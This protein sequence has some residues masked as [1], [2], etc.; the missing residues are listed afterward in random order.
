MSADS[1]GQTLVGTAS[2]T[3]RS[4]IQ[5][6]TFYPS[7]ASSAQARLRYYASQF[8]LVEVDSS[9][10]ALPTVENA[11]R[12]VE[13]T[14]DGFTFNVKAFGLFTTHPVEVSRLARDLREALPA[15]LLGK[16]SIYLRD[17]SRE[18][19]EETWRRFG[20]ALQPL[21]DAGKLGVVVFQFPRW[22]V[23]GRRAEAH[24]LR[25]RENLPQF[26]IGVEFRSQ[27]WFAE[28]RADGTIRFL[29]ES[30]LA[31]ICVDEPQG[32]ASSVPPVAEAT[33]DIAVVRF[34]GRNRATWEKRGIAA[35]DRF[36]YYYSA[37]ELSEWL[38]PIRRLQE[39]VSRVHLVMNTNNR[40][41][42]PVNARLLMEL[43]AD[44]GQA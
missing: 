16:R 12:W 3:D 39:R 11:R 43:L 2:W 4:L 7:G 44:F 31:F 25:C 36:D 30:G 18:F 32:F 13:R 10:Y 5:A 24:I 27:R 9:Y 38:G 35:S 28:D 14:P 33:A 37:D 40:D 17:V 8:P 29:R 15:S 22:F 1:L 6:G 34:H 42:G 26:S 21:E 20:E 19:T 41:Q 23:P